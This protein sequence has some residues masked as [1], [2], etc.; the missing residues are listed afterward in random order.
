M[1]VTSETYIDDIT[2]SATA[3]EEF[4]LT[5]PIRN[6]NELYVWTQDVTTEVYTRQYRGMAYQVRIE[7]SG[8]AYL[9]W[10]GT[11]PVGADTHIRAQRH[12]QGLQEGEYIT[13]YSNVTPTGFQVGIDAIIKI[14]LQTMRQD[15]EEKKHWTTGGE[16]ITGVGDALLSAEVVN[17]SQVVGAVGGGTSDWSIASEDVGQWATAD[18]AGGYTWEPFNGT[19]DPRGKEYK[20]LTGTGWTTIYSI[21]QVYGTKSENKLLMDVDGLPTWTAVQET[22]VTDAVSNTNWAVG[23]AVSIHRYDPGGGNVDAA[24][25]NDYHCAPDLLPNETSMRLTS[26]EDASDYAA[27]KGLKMEFSKQLKMTKHTVSCRRKPDSAY[28]YD[29]YSGIG[30]TTDYHGQCDHPVYVGSFVN[31]TADASAIPFFTPQLVSLPISY[32]VPEENP[33]E[34]LNF[35]Y[36]MNLIS[37]D[38]TTVTFAAASLLHERYYNTSWKDDNLPGWGDNTNQRLIAHP[39]TEDITFTVI[40]YVNKV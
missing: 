5:F 31:P 12:M 21:D 30:N 40:W 11:S 20:Y 14:A 7:D 6:N 13:S 28:A 15:L 18:G 37:I 4:L 25:F 26:I 3:N 39:E 17:K 32:V 36:V 27:A 35:T 24:G 1:T 22:P 8:A 23:R 9:V 19:P 10:I 34:F 16:R 38:A 2:P 29:D 33:H